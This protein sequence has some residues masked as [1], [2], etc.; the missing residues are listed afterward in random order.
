MEKLASVL[1]RYICSHNENSEF[2]YDVYRYS[3]L[4]LLEMAAGSVTGV[5]IAAYMAVLVE[6]AA[7]LLVFFLLRSYAGG[8]HCRTF[9]GCYVAST[10]IL[11]GAFWLVKHW[12]AEPYISLALIVVFGGLLAFLNGC[13]SKNRPVSREEAVCFKKKLHRILAATFT[14]YLAFLILGYGQCALS[15]SLAV[16]ASGMLMLIGKWKTNEKT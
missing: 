13:D 12:D 16:T 6:A 3:F 11:A 14:L 9:M 7:F 5:L 4:M 10:S 15:V 1:A 2:S 8:L